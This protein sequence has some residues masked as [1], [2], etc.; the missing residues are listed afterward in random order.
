MLDFG[1]SKL[2]KHLAIHP[3][4]T[5]GKLWL[6][7]HIVRI[8]SQDVRNRNT[9]CETQESK[10]TELHNVNVLNKETWTKPSLFIQGLLSCTSQSLTVYGTT[11]SCSSMHQN[12]VNNTK[13]SSGC[14]PNREISQE[15]GSHLATI[16]SAC[17]LSEKLA[18]KY[19]GPLKK[20]M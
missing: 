17:P 4:S 20:V 8:I 11:T 16:N 9:H 13:S 14:V 19:T 6:Y 3:F 18:E 12:T 10:H 2:K 5:P 15:F 7:D 1:I